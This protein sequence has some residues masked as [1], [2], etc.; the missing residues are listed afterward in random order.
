MAG[1]NGN[2]LNLTSKDL[3]DLARSYIL[4][5][6][7]KSAGMRRVDSMEGARIVGQKASASR[8]FSGVI[9]P[10][11]WP[12][13]KEP[14]EYRLRRDRP[15]LERQSDGSSKVRNKYLSPPGRGNYLYFD[16]LV[17]PDWLKTSEI[18][19]TITE[20]EKKKLAL[21]RFYNER[22]QKRLVIG[23]AGVWNWRGVIG[24]ET[25]VDGKKRDVK[26][27]I[28]DFDRIEWKGRDVLIV[29]DAR[30]D[31]SVTAA[32]KSLANE[33][34]SRGAK[35]CIAD[36]PD[37]KGVNGVDDLLGLKGPE[38]VAELFDKANFVQFE[39]ADFRVTD[40]GVVSLNHYDTRGNPAFICS[41]LNVTAHTR[42]DESNEWGRRLEW[43]DPD[44]R[45]HTWIMPTSLCSGDGAEIC[46][47]LLAGGLRISTG[48]GTRGLL[49]TYLQAAE[50]N[51]RA[52]CVDRVGWYRDRFVLPDEVIG[53]QA[54]EEIVLQSLTAEEHRL[55]TSGTLD[56]WRTEIGQLCAGNTRLIFS[57]SCAF[58]PPLLLPCDEPSGGFHLRGASSKGKTTCQYA[59]G[60]VWGGNHEKGYLRQWRATA[61]GIEAVAEVHNDG[62]LPLDELSECD[63]RTAG[64]VAYM[65]ANG[66]GKTRMARTLRAR[67]SSAW[68]L[69]FLSSGEVTLADHVAQAEKRVRAGQE[70]R[71]IDIEV[72]ADANLGA[73]EKLHE[74]DNADSFARHI[75][76]ASKSYYGAPIRAFLQAITSRIEEI[77]A[78]AREFVS[79]RVTGEAATWVRP[80]ASGEVF[81]AARRFALIAFAGELATEFGITG[82]PKGEADNAARR[83]FDEWVRRRGTFGSADDQAALRQ[84]RAFIEKHGA[85]RFQKI[86]DRLKRDEKTNVLL[87]DPDDPIVDDRPVVNRAGFV[88]PDADGNIT[89]YFISPEVFRREVCE[90]FDYEA[91]AKMLRNEGLLDVDKDRARNQIQIRT[92]EGRIRVYAVKSTILEM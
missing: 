11:F 92:P 73:F 38:F 47:Y 84:V 48:K 61:N 5:D 70:V 43:R 77:K 19:V 14:R 91:V 46:G 75:E 72:D 89:E 69:I 42:D 67:K 23:L 2:S 44:G 28:P 40:D 82:W 45:H 3:A 32:R 55:R 57:V 20:G 12:G 90:G 35:V 16:P 49:L 17:A 1:N 29:F 8:D 79:S 78:R 7:A 13:N 88:K 85:S 51:R 39:T 15:D 4:P 74:F 26:G 33:L 21:D 50:T 68:R 41:R 9:F 10:Y 64:E 34:I 54:A 25:D 27:V 80:D 87:P 6:Q 86:R 66:S 58:A 18:P 76:T 81:R 30:P 52:R 60:S 37:I 71:L 56:E 63:P 59:A 53:D 24:K 83:I 62:L 22:K 65:L 31:E 36:L